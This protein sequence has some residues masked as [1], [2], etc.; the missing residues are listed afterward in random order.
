[1]K[2]QVDNAYSDGHESRLFYDIE[3]SEVPEDRE[4]MWEHLWQFGGDGHGTDPDLGWCYE[5]TILEA[6]NP[7]LVGLSEENCGS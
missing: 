4:D 2:I 3:D 6:S 7:E 1:M 5:I